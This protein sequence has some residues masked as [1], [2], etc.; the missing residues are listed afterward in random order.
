MVLGLP[1]GLDVDLDRFDDKWREVEIGT[2]P[3]PDTSSVT[4]PVSGSIVD[5]TGGTR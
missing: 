3:S 1:A 5:K 2:S 4:A